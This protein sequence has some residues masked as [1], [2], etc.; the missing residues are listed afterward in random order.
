M[1][2]AQLRE[3]VHA[4]LRTT[5]LVPYLLGPITSGNFRLY[6]YYP[7]QHPVLSGGEPDEGWLVYTLDGPTIGEFGTIFEN[8]TVGFD[9]FTTRVSLAD[10]VL[11]QLDALW[12]WR[13]T[14]Q[15][16]ITIAEYLLLMSRRVKTEEVYAKDV[17]LYQRTTRY[18]WELVRNEAE[19]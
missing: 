11:D 16:D 15:K 13:I 1:S 17:H 9:V 10:D 5:P 8:A 14:Q 18:A 19:G 6:G 7:Q 2:R 12:Q 4:Q 3:Y